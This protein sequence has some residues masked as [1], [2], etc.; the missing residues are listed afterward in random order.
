MR[1]KH[2]MSRFV[3]TTRARGE[4]AGGDRSGTIGGFSRRPAGFSELALRLQPVV[5]VV[6]VLAAA[7]EEQLVRASRD[8]FFDR[9]SPRL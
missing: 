8:R 4:F 2:L 6:A 5:E 1:A 7:R 9:I 3:R